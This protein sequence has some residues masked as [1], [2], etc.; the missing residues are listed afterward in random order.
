ML[1]SETKIRKIIKRLILENKSEMYYTDLETV[2]DAINKHVPTPF[3][4]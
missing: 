3:N 1:I 2:I 4:V